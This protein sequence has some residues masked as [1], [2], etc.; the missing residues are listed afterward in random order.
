MDSGDNIISWQRHFSYIWPDDYHKKWIP[1]A[2]TMSEAVRGFNL[3]LKST[4]PEGASQ[5]LL[6]L[7]IYIPEDE[8]TA[9]WNIRK[10]VPNPGHTRTGD[11]YTNKRGHFLYDRLV[12]EGTRDAVLDFG[13]WRWE[14][15]EA[16][17]A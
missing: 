1:L 7:K 17:C 3:S 2:P 14:W 6:I 11:S 13:Q 4:G 9:L 12:K 5:E 16:T 10:I 8:W 15:E